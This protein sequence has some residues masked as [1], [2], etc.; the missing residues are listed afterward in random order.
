M[1]EPKIAQD[2]PTMT[3][4]PTADLNRLEDERDAALAWMREYEDDVCNAFC[5]SKWT[6]VKGQPHDPRHLYLRD[7]LNGEPEMRMHPRW[8]GGHP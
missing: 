5:P 4:I 8:R 3:S 6:T 1:S 7:I 2:H